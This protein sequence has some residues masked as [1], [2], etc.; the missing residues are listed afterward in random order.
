MKFIETESRMVVAK[1]GQGWRNGEL[2][3]KGYRVSVW[4]DGKVLELMVVMAAQQRE[5]T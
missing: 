3:F 1:V 2:V 4:Q 5:C